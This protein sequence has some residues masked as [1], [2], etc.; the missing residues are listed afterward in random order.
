MVTVDIWFDV[1]CPW[2]YV[3]KRRWETALAA[4]PNADLI[5][6][7]WRAFELR[8][9]HSR[10]PTRTLG[11]IM[12]SDWNLP[13][14]EPSKI[15]ERV[16]AAGRSEGL[17]LRPESVRPVNTFDAHRLTRLAADHGLA[18]PVI[19]RLFVAYHTELVNIADQQVLSGLAID[20]GLDGAAIEKLWHGDAYTDDV[21]ADRSAAAEAG[22]TAVPSYRIGQGAAVS[23]ALSVDRLRSLL[24]TEGGL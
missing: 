2:C 22:V 6:V 8:P 19:E 17:V 24:E 9:G 14:G 13:P 3:G 20:V 11:E 12:R 16:E 4:F 23:G 15:V 10:T 1:V 21:R 18:D 5:R 7:R